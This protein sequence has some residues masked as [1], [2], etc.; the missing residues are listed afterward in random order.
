MIYGIPA[1]LE[2]LSANVTL[3]TGDLVLTGTPSGVGPMSLGDTVE[4]EIDGVGTLR[5]HVVR[6]H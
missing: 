2:F 4:V 5:N 3:E 6:G 1:I